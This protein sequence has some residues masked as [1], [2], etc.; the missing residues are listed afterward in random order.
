MCKGLPMELHDIRTL[1]NMLDFAVEKYPENDFILYK[2]NGATARKSYT[3]F[4]QSADAFSRM[5][6]QRGLRGAHVAVIGPTCFEWI[7]TYFGTVAADS[8]I[9]PLAANET[10]E[11]N[12]QL[13]AFGD[14][15]VLV[16]SKKQE[17][18]YR[19]VKEKLP[20]VKLFISMDGLVQEDDVLPFAAIGDDYAGKYDGEPAADR[21]CTLLFTSGTTGFP[22]GVM[23]NQYNLVNSA[24]S[25]WEYD[26][27]MRV[28]CCLPISHA[29]CFTTNIVKVIFRG[30]AVCVN[31]DMA[32]LLADIRLFAPQSIVCV[33]LIANKLMGGALRYA[34]TRPDLEE[35]DAVKE[36]LGGC[37]KIVSGGAPLEAANNARYTQAGMI[38]LNGYGMTECSPIIANNTI[39]FRKNGSVGRT[40]PCMQVKIENGEIL[41]KGAGVM[42]GYYKNEEATAQAFTQDCW[43]H[44]G[45]LGYIDEE[46][47]LFITGRCK[48][49]ILLDNG[50]NVSAEF[51]EERFAKAALVQ[52][53]VAYG[54][55]GMICVEIFPNAEYVSSHAIDDV[56]AAVSSLIAEINKELAVFQ[57]ITSFV[58]RDTPFERTASSKIKRTDGRPVAKAAVEKPL[59]PAEKKVCSAVCEVLN[60]EEVGINQN[61]FAIGG[62]SLSATE[63][64]VTLNIGTQSVYD[65]PVLRELARLL[66]DE[67]TSDE[68]GVEGIN[69]VISKTAGQGADVKPY[70]TVLLT[71]AAGFLGAHVFRELLDRD[72]TIYCL[73]RNKERF[74]KQIEYYFGKLSYPQAH[75][76][77]G[78]IEKENLGLS[79]YL[80]AQ[81]CK[82]VD[83]VFHV[84]ANVHHAGDYAQLKKT[85]VDGTENCIAFAK[86][87][88]AV[89]HH[90]S[91]VSVHGAATVPQGNK[92]AKFDEF[93]LAIGQHFAENVYIHS[94]YRAEEAVLTARLDGVCSNIYRIGNLTWRAC[95]GL[96]QI[97][98]D[99]N[100]FLHRIRAMLKLGLLSSAA[101]KYP[102][103]LTAVDECAKAFVGLAFSGKVNEI[104]HLYNPNYLSAENLFRFLAVPFRHASPLEVIETAF[105]NTHD[106]DIQV[107][108]FYMLISGRSAN[109]ETSCRF[110]LQRMNALGLCWSVP[111]AEYLRK[112]NNCLPSE[113]MQI[114]AMRSSGGVMTPIQKLFVSTLRKA[115]LPASEMFRG[116][117]SLLLLAQYMKNSGIKKP[118]V[119]TF[120][121][122]LQFDHVQE[123][124]AAFN[125]NYALFTD[126]P[127]EPSLSCVRDCIAVYKETQCDGIVAVGGGSVLDCAKVSALCVG[128]DGKHPDA[129][130]G[131]FADAAPAVPFYAVP[132]TAGT[133]S[134]MTV[135]A[136]ITDDDKQ[137][138][139]P[140][141]SDRFLPLA[142]ALDPALTVGLPY[143]ATAATGLDALSHAIEAYLSLYADYFPED[144]DAAPLVC[145]LVFD[146]LLTAC[147]KPDCLAARLHMLEAANLGGQAFRRISTGYIHA[148]AHRLGEFY[149]LA[150]GVAI[151]CCIV[152]VLHAYL[153]FG[154]K[155]LA[156]LAVFCGFASQETDTA[157]AAQLFIDAVESLTE[158]LQILQDVVFDG[159]YTELII[160]R[161]QDEVKSLGYPR[162]FSDAQLKEI[163]KQITEI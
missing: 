89:L 43:L 79:P 112:G 156:K 80:Y 74:E 30:A 152:P 20:R 96:F 59:T 146:N 130:C 144:R 19:L 103:D 25:V 83:A 33:P 143:A 140:Y 154:E 155:P 53:V 11:M 2:E 157:Q 22:K 158:K 44:T 4:Q 13:C 135:F 122:A 119:I 162:P 16:F 47:F 115:D 99:D 151:G 35:S 58:L 90:T 70:K 26:D 81:L 76:V 148:I 27:A 42:L 23:L 55:D 61:F 9:I 127:G 125:N 88:G 163:V 37:G 94:K 116:N 124:L 86:A 123:F 63:L 138:K 141:L 109:I 15:D 110:T 84:A 5:L 45:D 31:S 147:E 46:G 24:M 32:E 49:L 120:S 50:E 131:L 92:T 107:Y 12:L 14:A 6:I 102:M 78:N 118:L 145:K 160:D 29:Y 129:V 34:K 51:L 52:E 153:P 128:N 66:A 41:V 100:G 72:V 85:N 134:E 18:L 54:Q 91:T 8:V 114:K 10:Q 3:Q 68:K 67:R 65:Y 111:D 108:M 40:I 95:D 73:V 36:F 93:T 121:A 21:F 105:A 57:R 150:H 133:G 139:T 56:S 136:V 113:T 142:V 98:T 77:I 137:M 117:D 28:F 149:H 104:Y 132:T 17:G 82:E 38:V 126:I 75:I 71:G 161:A 64:A 60:K 101:D 39:S 159:D 48:N 97:N 106:R 69:S 1:K 87:A 7:V 62:N